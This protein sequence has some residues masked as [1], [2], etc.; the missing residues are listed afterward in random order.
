[1]AA[2]TV[3]AD[4]LLPNAIIAAAGLRGRNTRN[5]TRR[6]SQGGFQNINVNWQRTLREYDLGY[7]PMLPAQWATIEGIHEVTAGGAYGF[8]LE[9]PKDQAATVATGRAALISGTN[10]QLQ[11]LY[12]S[13]GST[14]TSL[15][16]ITRPRA[17]GFAIF[18]SGTPIG[19]FTLNAA[20]GVVTIP[21]APAAA[22]LTWS[23]VFYVPV[24][25]AVDDLD[26]DLVAGG[27]PDTRLVMGSG[28]LLKE[29]RE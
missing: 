19:T 28:V 4:V 13:V 22:T 17:S 12:T 8:L 20:T 23:G 7:I 24:H 10:Y 2:L 27:S 15:R 26:W 3:Y 11:K 6:M 1:M 21:S 25:F 9:D 18:T 16:T 5:N 29:V 14:R